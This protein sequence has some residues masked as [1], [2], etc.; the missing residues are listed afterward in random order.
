M[1]RYWRLVIV[2][3][4]VDR[5]ASVYTLTCPRAEASFSRLISG[6]D[7]RAALFLRPFDNWDIYSGCFIRRLGVFSLR[8]VPSSCSRGD[9]K[10]DCAVSAETGVTGRRRRR[11]DE[12]CA[13]HCNDTWRTRSPRKHVD[14]QQEQG[15][16]ARG[17]VRRGLD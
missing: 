13:L 14:F 1:Y 15:K 17:R 7:K 10:W 5:A 6:A 16:S 2:A 11:L 4:I 12:K 9:C 8:R 3:R